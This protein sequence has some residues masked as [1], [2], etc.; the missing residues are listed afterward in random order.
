LDAA[1]GAADG[2]RPQAGG[3]PVEGL[4]LEQVRSCDE[5]ELATLEP[6][7]KVSVIRKGR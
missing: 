2:V 7:G 3:R 1:A 5:V 4:R 6:S